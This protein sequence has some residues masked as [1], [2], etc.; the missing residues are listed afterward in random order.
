MRNRG[1]VKGSASIG[2]SRSRPES[3][4]R[5][6]SAPKGN[7]SCVMVIDDDDEIRDTLQAA[8]KKD[9]EVVCLESGEEAPDLIESFKP[10]LL[11]LDIN[12]PG[13]DGFE[14]CAAVRA[15]AKSRNLPV[16]FMTARKDDASFLRSLQVGGD[17]YITKPFEIPALQ[18]RIAYLLKHP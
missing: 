17:S 1:P 5:D 10:E 16:L 8:L 9:Y 2:K 18:D 4:S 3:D 14:V 11:I 7:P 13:S 12:M 6:E 15:R